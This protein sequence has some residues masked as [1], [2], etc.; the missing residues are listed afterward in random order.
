MGPQ[1]LWKPYVEILARLKDEQRVKQAAV[2][3]SEALHFEG[4]R[5]PESSSVQ[6]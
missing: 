3:T 5:E 2:L 6:A 1:Y 4:L